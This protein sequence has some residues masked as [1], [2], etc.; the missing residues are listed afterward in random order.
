MIVI[1]APSKSKADNLENVHSESLTGKISQSR[2]RLIIQL[3][4]I[5]AVF[6]A[7]FGGVGC[8]LKVFR[9]L[10]AHLLIVLET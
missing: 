10:Y 8:V 5:S 1:G 3:V 6:F 4:H 7:R 2:D 9:F